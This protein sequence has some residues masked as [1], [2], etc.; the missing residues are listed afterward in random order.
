MG[1]ATWNGRGQTSTQF[2]VI[3]NYHDKTA[4]FIF[5]GYRGSFIRTK[6]FDKIMRMSHNS[7]SVIMGIFYSK[8]RYLYWDQTL[9][10]NLSCRRRCKLVRG[11]RFEE[12]CRKSFHASLIGMKRNETKKRWEWQHEMAGAKRQ[13]NS[14]W[15]WIITTKLHFSYS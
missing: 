10:S 11:V 5:L 3:L 12:I 15:S 6:N 2:T 13:P 4:F 8:R 14:L 1:M 7:L 9:Y